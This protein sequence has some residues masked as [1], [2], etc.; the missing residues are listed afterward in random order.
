MTSADVQRSLNDSVGRAKRTS[1]V[2]FSTVHVIGE[3]TT[4]RQFCNLCEDDDPRK[5][6]VRPQRWSAWRAGHACKVEGAKQL[7]M[8][9]AFY[10]VRVI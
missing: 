10:F 1:R 9:K 2:E 5:A 7:R 6:V 3:A 8:L 4:T